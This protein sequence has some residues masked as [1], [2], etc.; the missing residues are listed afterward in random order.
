MSLVNEDVVHAQ[1]VEHQA[2]IFFL[3]GQQ[4]CEPFLT[5]GFLLLQ[6]FE[7]VAVRAGRLG[8]SAVAQ[9]LVIGGDLLPQE[10]LLVC[11]GHADALERTVRGNDPIPR[12]AG[13]AGGQQLAPTAWA[14][15]V[16]PLLMMRQ[17]ASC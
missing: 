12:T 10:P 9:E 14:R 15:S 16:L 4:V 8:C 13:D 1:F 5:P 6:G 7:D 2:V 11:T 3:L 17:T